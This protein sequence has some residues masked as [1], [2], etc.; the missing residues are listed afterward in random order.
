L[1]K[2]L[3]AARPEGPV[4]APFILEEMLP[5][6]DYAEVRV[7]WDRWARLSLEERNAVILEAFRRVREYEGLMKVSSASGLTRAR[8]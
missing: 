7:I 4:D 2:E 6:S 8:S 5:L 3:E 1:S